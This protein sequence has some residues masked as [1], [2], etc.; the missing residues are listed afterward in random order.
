MSCQLVYIG[1][2]PLVHPEL[3]CIKI[4][5][6]TFSRGVEGVLPQPH[7]D[8]RGAESVEKGEFIGDVVP[9]REAPVL[10]NVIVNNNVL[11]EGGVYLNVIIAVCSHHHHHQS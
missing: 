6:S 5:V 3:H 10:E 8:V 1:H 11:P 2:L 7:S 4:D 9:S